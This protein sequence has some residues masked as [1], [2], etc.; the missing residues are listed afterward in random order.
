MLES[1]SSANALNFD[2]L[3]IPNFKSDPMAAAKDLRI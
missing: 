2:S 3:L 1:K